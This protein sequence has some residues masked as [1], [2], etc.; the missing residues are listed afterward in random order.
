MRVKVHLPTCLGNAQC[1]RVAPQVFAIGPEDVV[2][3]LLPSPPEALRE[4]LERA[5]RLCP[6]QSISLES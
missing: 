1:V 5:V 6:T 4:E 3:L 2:E